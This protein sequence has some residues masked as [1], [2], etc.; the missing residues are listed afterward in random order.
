MAERFGTVLVVLAVGLFIAL[1]T[2]GVAAGKTT[3]TP[4]GRALATPIPGAS[5]L[6]ADIEA[7]GDHIEPGELAD[8][9]LAGDPDLLVVDIRPAAEFDAFHIRGAQNVALSEL[10]TYLRPYQNRGLIV[11]YSNGMTH[12]AQA[13]DYLFSRG[14]Q[15]A[16]IL[17][18]GLIGFIERCL[19]PVSLRPGPVPKDLASRI[20]GWRAYFLGRLTE[21]S[22]DREGAVSW[23]ATL[24]YVRSS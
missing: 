2:E 6:L 22:R 14:F 10:E 23:L 4:V 5:D 1:P 11:L 18:D 12:P 15:N 3:S 19:K 17:T 20:A 16:Y 7:A 21:P 13:R 24:G 9:L 8:R